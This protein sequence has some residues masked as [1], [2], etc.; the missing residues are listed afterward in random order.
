MKKYRIMNK[1][2]KQWWEGE[3]ESAQ[4][5]CQAAGWPIGDCWVREWTRKSGRYGGWG[6]PTDAPELGKR[7]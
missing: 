1:I 4:E 3:A 7:R 5:A 6:N 2:T